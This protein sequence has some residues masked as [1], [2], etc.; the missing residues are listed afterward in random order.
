V[1]RSHWQI[2][3]LLAQELTSAQVAA[4]PG[5]TGN[6]IRT[7]A[8]RYNQQGPA[9]GEDRRHR[10]PGAGGLLS[11]AQRAA[12]AAALGQPPPAGAQV[13]GVVAM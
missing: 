9:G 7:L 11:A 4:V 6:W 13:Q 1:A 3:W 8:R 12:L 2:I 5:Y 10:N